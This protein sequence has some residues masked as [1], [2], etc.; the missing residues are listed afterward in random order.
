MLAYFIVLLVSLSIA[1]MTSKLKAI[2]PLYNFFIFFNILF[3]TLFAGLRN[4]SVGTDT[5]SYVNRFLGNEPVF[6]NLME[7]VSS[8]E[9]GYQFIEVMVSKFSS[10]Y[11]SLLI[12]IAFITVFFQIKG[13]Y[14]VSIN[15]IVSILVLITFGFYLFSFNGAR[16]GIALSI[17]IYAIQFIKNKKFIKYALCIGLGYLFHKTIIITLPM[18]FLFRL[19][20]SFKLFSIIAISTIAIILFF[21]NI[22]KLGILIS[23][24]YAIYSELKTSGGQL[25]T[26]AYLIFGVFFILIKPFLKKECYKEY[27]IYLNM[28]LIGPIIY[29]I[30]QFTGAYIEITRL[31]IYFLS[32]ALFLWPLILKNINKDFKPITFVFF[33]ISNLIFFFIFINKI[34]SLVPYQLNNQLFYHF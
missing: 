3:L 18:Y 22:L 31:A 12:T 9:I 15:P 19:K 26:L 33:I 17:F 28:F 25:L 13:I 7:G 6:S 4:S 23:N 34:G 1:Y 11:Y 20:F 24:K 30:V 29:T 14:K 8:M 32:G 27:D 21:E 16:Q 5:N 10:E 2:K